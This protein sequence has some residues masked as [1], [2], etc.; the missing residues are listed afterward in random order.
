MSGATKIEFC[1]MTVNPLVGCSRKSPG[2]DHCYAVTMARR[3]GGNPK[4]PQYH[5]LTRMSIGGPEWTGEV[6]W[7]PGVL[8]KAL[9]GLTLCRTSKRVFI[10]SMSDIAHEK[11]TLQHLANVYAF[12]AALPRHKIILITKRPDLLLLRTRALM[13]RLENFRDTWDAARKQLYDA[14]N[15]AARARFSVNRDSKSALA[16][17]NKAEAIGI[18]YADV[19]FPLKNVMLMA[20]VEDQERLEERIEP[21]MEL[22]ARGWHTGLI[23]E[24]M[25]SGIDP[26]R[27]TISNEDG[28]G[29]NINALEGTAWDE[30]NGELSTDLDG[31]VPAKAIE[32]FVCGM[33]QGPGRRLLDI[34]FAMARATECAIAGVPCF[35]KKD[36]YG[37]YPAQMP[38]HFPEW[39]LCDGEAK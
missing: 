26:D 9:V 28:S 12:A 36:S 25:L 34:R 27:I 10:C 1:H 7:V 6:R 5:G 29:Y 13:E 16:L 3:H 33:E 30:E 22:A 37:R 8:E 18:L 23:S 35:F 4:T 2:C 15:A 39:M 38:R 17:Q 19:R 31:E 32:W 14:C 11:A 24:P 20:T 21:M